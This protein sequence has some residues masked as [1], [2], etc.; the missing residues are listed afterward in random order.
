[1]KRYIVGIW[2]LTRLG[3]YV[4]FVVITT[5]LGAAAGKATL[6]VSLIVVLL[7][8]LLA[9]GFAFMVNDVEDAN[10]DA[11]SPAKASRNPVSSG[12]L[13]PT[14]AW[15]AALGVG[16]CG[17]AL[18]AFL[19]IGPFLAGLGCLA[20]A[21][22]YSSRHVRLKATP[23]ADLVSHALMLAGLQFIAAYVAFNR[24]PIPQWLFPLLLV[25]AISLYGQLFNELR[26]FDGDV[27]AGVNHTAALLGKR[28][29]HRL[30]MAW[31]FV[32]VASAIV[33]VLAFSFV[34]VWVILL[35]L[36]LTA[37]LLWRRFHKLQR[38]DPAIVLH[39]ALHK[40]VE[41]ATALALA[42]WFAGPWVLASLR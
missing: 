37:L 4:S 15:R 32:G 5:L 21:Y 14:V 16:F 23:I 6:S 11:M 42:A 12:L 24:T 30:M 18:Y 19:G 34:P 29:S 31:L 25:L 13:T 41:I 35:T 10:D 26:D 3:E 1:M 39:E 38:N 2:K 27:R 33:A 40:P 22:L 36:V 8:N 20:L 7:A 9:V 28:A 17:L